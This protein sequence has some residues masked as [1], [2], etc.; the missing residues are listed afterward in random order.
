[1]RTDLVPKVL[2]FDVHGRVF[3]HVDPGLGEGLRG[4]HDRYFVIG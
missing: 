2:G 1:M 4:W 3:G